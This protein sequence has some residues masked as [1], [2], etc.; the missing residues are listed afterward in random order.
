M[1]HNFRP[2]SARA[3]ALE[4][5][6]NQP[7]KLVSFYEEMLGVKF[8]PTGYPFKRYYTQVG[9][10]ALIIGE[11]MG[12]DAATASEPGKVTL[13][14]IS[15]REIPASERTFLLPHHRPLGDAIPERLAAR[16]QDPDGNHIA[17]VPSLE[18]II[19]ILPGF[20]SASELFDSVR[21]FSLVWM[22]QLVQI[23]RRQIEIGIDRCE[24]FTN[25][26]TF[27]KRNLRGYTHFVAAQNGLYAVNSTSY[28]RILRGKFYG[29][30]IRDGELYA[31]QAM[32][33]GETK[34]NPNGRILKITI[35]NDRIEKV[36]VVANGLDSGCHQIDF[37]GDDLLVVD[38]YNGAILQMRPGSSEEPKAYYPLGKIS[39]AA[40]RDQYHM[41]S[42]VGHPDGTV[43]VL[44][45]HSGIERSEI[46]VLD[47]QFEIMRRFSVDAAAAHNIVFTNDRS[48]YLISDSLGGRVISSNGVAIDG[49]VGMM[50]V[51]GLSLDENLCV[52]GDSIFGSRPLR[53]FVPG[54]V[55]FFDRHTWQLKSMLTLP[56]A[57]TDIRR[58]DGKDFS[59]SNYFADQV[60]SNN[61]HP[62]TMTEPEPI[63]S[64]TSR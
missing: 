55:H 1:N 41:N 6:T 12:R 4:L 52:V 16:L 38:C 36:K 20:T 25:G 37:V 26:V 54:R 43:W 10:F 46:I 33:E 21:E 42:I 19:G 15:G 64:A 11:A 18:R 40:A 29:I 3:F 14:L 9:R 7:E 59:I 13:A 32:G 35:Q 31:Y 5:H 49:G 53:R 56:G 60:Q 34:S 23:V 8:Y 24:M 2:S 63:A 28:Q 47:K 58:I 39:R 45:H 61:I 57:P 17:L 30:T 50:M 48:E 22:T 44:L 51:R 27:L 62:Q